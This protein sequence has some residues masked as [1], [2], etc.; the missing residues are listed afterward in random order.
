M[1]VAVRFLSN[2]VEEFGHHHVSTDGGAWYPQA[3]QFFKYD[4]SHSF[5]F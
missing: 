3:C 5:S 4:A 1:F 2:I